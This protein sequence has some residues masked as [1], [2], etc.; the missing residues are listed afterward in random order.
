VSIS[1]TLDG[2]EG[3]LALPAVLERDI[4]Q[5]LRK[6]GKA[7]AVEDLA[8]LLAGAAELYAKALEDAGVALPVEEPPGR[9]EGASVQ[10][11]R[12]TARLSACA[13]AAQTAFAEAVSSGFRL[14]G[15]DA[16]L[17]D[18][19][20]VLRAGFLALDEAVSEL[21]LLPG[22]PAASDLPAPPAKGDAAGLAAGTEAR[23]AW[24]ARCSGVWS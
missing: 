13:A 18:C 22:A 14:A 1:I 20:H 17:S 16:D 8:P 11:A 12:L 7:Q 21:A 9:R 23:V 24:L 2:A 19:G 5:L 3:V 10:G 4:A 15:A 6:K